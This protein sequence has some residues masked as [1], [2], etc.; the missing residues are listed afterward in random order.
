MLFRLSLAACLVAQSSALA[1]Q[2]V[3]IRRA[4]VVRSAAA[5]MMADPEATRDPAPKPWQLDG[6]FGDIVKKS[7]GSASKHSLP[8]EKQ[9]QFVLPEESFKVSKMEMSQ[10]DE[11]FELECTPFH[12]ADTYIMVEPMFI[13][14][15]KYFMGFT[16]D[17]DP[18][19]TIDNNLVEG[20]M[21]TKSGKPTAI[22][23]KFTPDGETGE[24]TAYLCFILPEEK[25]FSKFYKITAKSQ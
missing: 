1:V 19:I 4:A 12:E 22:K 16:S 21:N 14:K 18:K 17:S 23:I 24:F 10:T 6:G 15:A 7:G 9:A 20:E 5:S 8:P 2:P 3:R 25:T 11:D 13:T